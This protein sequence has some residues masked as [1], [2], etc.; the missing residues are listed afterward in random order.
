MRT[1]W[2]FYAQ[3]SGQLWRFVWSCAVFNA[4]S[5]TNNDVLS[6]MVGGSMR[7]QPRPPTAEDLQRNVID[8]GERYD[9]MLSTDVKV[10][11]VNGVV[12]IQSV[13]HYYQ[14][15]FI[16]IFRLFNEAKL[17]DIVY[18]NVKTCNYDSP[19][20]VQRWAIPMLMQGMNF[21]ACAVTGSGKTAAYLI[22]I[23]SRMMTER[24]IGVPNADGVRRPSTLILVPT[25]ELASSISALYLQI[26]QTLASAQY[27]YTAVR[28]LWNRCRH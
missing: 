17:H 6:R 5:G 28:V 27:V 2:T 13:I 8:A 16:P 23:L 1:R 4:V 9:V 10:F 12:P 25:R 26:C 20:P 3:L 7:H 15:N 22:P 14:N 24:R 11:N 19:T 18:V 21:V